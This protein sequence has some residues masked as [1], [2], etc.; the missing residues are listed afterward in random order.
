MRDHFRDFEEFLGRGSE[1]DILY[2]SHG[3]PLESAASSTDADIAAVVQGFA[4]SNE[5]PNPESDEY[6]RS[7]QELL[8]DMKQDDEQALWT[9]FERYHPILTRY[10]RRFFD[11]PHVANQ[12]AADAFLKLKDKLA[13]AP[14]TVQFDLYESGGLAY[15]VRV[16]RNLALDCLKS[17]NLRDAPM[18]AGTF[19]EDYIPEERR[20]TLFATGG[21]LGASER[22]I[23][24]PERVHQRETLLSGIKQIPGERRRQVLTL[25]LSGLALSTIVEEIGCDAGYAAETLK[26]GLKQLSGIMSYED[27]EVKLLDVPAKVFDTRP[28]S[29]EPR[30]HIPNSQIRL[31]DEVIDLVANSRHKQLLSAYRDGLTMAEIADRL[32]YKTPESVRVALHTVYQAVRSLVDYDPEQGEV[33][34]RKSPPEIPRSS[35]RL[36]QEDIDT[37][38]SLGMRAVMSAHYTLGLTDAEIV[39]QLGF[40]PET[41][42]KYLQLG[43]GYLRNTGNFTIEGDGLEFLRLE[44]GLPEAN[45]SV[46]E[47]ITSV[48]NVR[49]RHALLFR[50]TLGL[51]SKEIAEE[52]MC[53]ESTARRYLENG[54]SYLRVNKLVT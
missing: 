17:P 35:M 22:D 38:P 12:V 7:D 52:L 53:S 43:Y 37:I 33:K 18:P 27:G 8:E 47:A 1:H 11:D 48:P 54:Y 45:I 21:M 31:T 13:R 3:D 34:M 24:D 40:G 26:V 39:D 32:G 20:N 28:H 9:L 44:T 25:F 29:S 46:L 4:Q 50:F 41:V 42:K 10:A 51:S 30:T 36:S 19:S 16:T 6:R 15:M 49:A 5:S 14:D 23:D 2:E